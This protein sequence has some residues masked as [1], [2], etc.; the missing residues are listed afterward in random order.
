M[1]DHLEMMED[2]LSMMED[3]LEVVEDDLE[4]F[5]HFR[6]VQFKPQNDGILLPVNDGR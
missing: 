6:K 5:C 1:E 4:F 3:Y 2:D